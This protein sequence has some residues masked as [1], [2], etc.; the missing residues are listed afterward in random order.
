MKK[1][2]TI[3]IIS[4]AFFASCGTRKCATLTTDEG[5]VIDGVR[6]ATRN[7]D[8]P[9]TFAPYP[10]SFGMLF[11]WGRRKG[12]AVTG[13]VEGWDS[14]CY[15]GVN[16]EKENDPCPEGWRVPTFDEIR[17]FGHIES[18]WITKNGVN[19]RLLGTAPYQIFLP[20][21]GFRNIHGFAFNTNAVG[22]YWSGSRSRRSWGLR[23][24]WHFWFHSVSTEG[25]SGSRALGYSIRCV[26]I[27]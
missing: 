17:T 8:A 21:A 18:E 10:E 6:W 5:V 25:S 20:A 12:W 3:A 9:G 16:W 26:A 13:D 11:Q 23:N 1:I 15:E 24:E 7:V 22:F 27:E 14:Y 4:I 19:G 2:L